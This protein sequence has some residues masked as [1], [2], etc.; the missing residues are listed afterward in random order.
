MSNK[1]NYDD[2]YD[3]FNDYELYEH[4]KGDKVKW[5]ISFALIALL[6]VGMCASFYM[7]FKDKDDTDTV[8]EPK[9]EDVAP[10]DIEAPEEEATA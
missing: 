2:Y 6:L 5:I 10:A 4:K 7:I 1:Y 3:D 8:K 9:T